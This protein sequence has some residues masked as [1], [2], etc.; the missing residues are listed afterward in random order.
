M[1]FCKYC[2]NYGGDNPDCKRDFETA[3][4]KYG[5]QATEYRDVVTCDL[6]FSPRE[7]EEVE[8]YGF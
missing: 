8:L 7:A 1:I 4:D 5:K 6:Y 2:E 3:I